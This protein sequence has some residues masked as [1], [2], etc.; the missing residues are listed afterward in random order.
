MK[1]SKN[2]GVML[3][4]LAVGTLVVGC[5]SDDADA[6]ESGGAQS[7][8]VVETNPDQFAALQKM[9]DDTNAQMS[10]ETQSGG[11]SPFSNVRLA[12]HEPYVLNYTYTYAEQVD[13]VETSTKL[14]EELE[15]KDKTEVCKEAFGSLTESGVKGPWT[16]GYE[17]LNADGS[18]ISTQVVDC[19]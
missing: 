1:L 8:V 4:A 7:A 14:T 3:V 15:A 6:P 19:P 12:A 2:I 9:V 11:D 10:G 5:S 17:Y 16:I 13:P 18:T